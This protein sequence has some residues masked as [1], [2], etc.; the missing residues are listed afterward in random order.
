MS[1]RSITCTFDIGENRISSV[2]DV[3]NLRQS[4]VLNKLLEND[5]GKPKIKSIR[6]PVYNMSDKSVHHIINYL[7]ENKASCLTDIEPLELVDVL[8]LSI[9][10]KIKSLELLI[11]NFLKTETNILDRLKLDKTDINLFL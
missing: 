11:S 7:Q 9:F 2:L 3:K 10:L 5:I 8:S 4:A 1:E 6:I